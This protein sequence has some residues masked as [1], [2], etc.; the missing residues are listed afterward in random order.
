MLHLHHHTFHK[1]SL[2]L[3][4]SYLL[5][6]SHNIAILRFFLKKSNIFTLTNTISKNKLFQIEKVT[7]YSS[8]FH[9]RSAN[10]IFI[11]LAS[12]I[13]LLFVVKIISCTFCNIQAR[14]ILLINKGATRDEPRHDWT[15]LLQEQYH[16]DP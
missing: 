11:L 6:S 12:M 8:W 9:N 16:S 14:H 3:Y 5:P 2:S 13:I 7:C 10:I 15:L 4:L 1:L